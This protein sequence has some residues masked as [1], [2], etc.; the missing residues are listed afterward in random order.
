M[1]GVQGVLEALSP[2]EVGLLDAPTVN[3]ELQLAVYS[4]Q[5]KHPVQQILALAEE[6]PN[7]HHQ[8]EV[9]EEPLEVNHYD[10]QFRA[11]FFKVREDY[12]EVL[13]NFN[14]QTPKNPQSYVYGLLSLE[15][16]DARLLL[17]LLN[18]ALVGPQLQ[19]V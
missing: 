9:S 15:F 2:L 14:H 18:E 16:I 11:L 3:Q 5:H 6:A 19:L 7:P 13:E 12:K 4:K 1:E 8:Q 10:R 17:R